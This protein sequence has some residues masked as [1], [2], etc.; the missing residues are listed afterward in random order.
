MPNFKY[1]LYTFCTIKR[2]QIVLCLLIYVLQNTCNGISQK[3]N[4]T[5]IIVIQNN[6]KNAKI[7]VL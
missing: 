7:T 6:K 4:I 1:M 5:V 3:Y 2:V